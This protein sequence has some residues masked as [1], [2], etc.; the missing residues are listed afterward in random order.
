MYIHNYPVISVS[1]WLAHDPAIWVKKKLIVLNICGWRRV[2]VAQLVRAPDLEIT[3]F[4]CPKGAGSSLGH[5]NV[6]FKLLDYWSLAL[7]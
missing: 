4:E 3:E 1:I 7:G 6:F 5:V 2:A